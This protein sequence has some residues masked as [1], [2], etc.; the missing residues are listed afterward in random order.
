MYAIDE[1]AA[2]QIKSL[3]NQ[4]LELNLNLNPDLATELEADLA[5]IAMRSPI[6]YITLLRRTG[7]YQ[8]LEGWK[9]LIPEELV[10][11]N[12]EIIHRYPQLGIN[13]ENINQTWIRERVIQWEF[14]HME[15]LNSP[16]YHIDPNSG[17][18]II[19]LENNPIP[20]EM[21][22]SVL[23][24]MRHENNLPVL[25]DEYSLAYRWLVYNRPIHAPL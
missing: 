7:L 17:R 24:D 23:E 21:I 25:G 1:L 13:H 18:P 8:L 10:E 22:I 11:I 15:N 6:A 4:L 16:T 12:Q 9:D 3:V 5:Y 20:L 19:S 2:N 14:A